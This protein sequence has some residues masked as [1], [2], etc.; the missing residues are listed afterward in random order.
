MLDLFYT[1]FSEK[2]D[3]EWKLQNQNYSSN[4]KNYFTFNHN[5]SQAL[6]IPAVYNFR[7]YKLIAGTQQIFTRSKLVVKTEK[8]DIWLN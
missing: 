6:I 2:C 8:H 7:F 4:Q 1:N 5:G 3:F